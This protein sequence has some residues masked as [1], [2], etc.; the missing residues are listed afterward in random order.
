MLRD[1]NTGD[2]KM[3]IARNLGM[4]HRS[5]FPVGGEW[6]ETGDGVVGYW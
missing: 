6:S 4:T 3:E 2:W 5:C 1:T